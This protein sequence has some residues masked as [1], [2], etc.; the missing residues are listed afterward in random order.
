MARDLGGVPHA[1]VR[2]RQALGL[3]EWP[4]DPRRVG[5]QVHVVEKIAVRED[6]KQP[7]PGHPR[8]QHRE[9][10]IDDDVGT[11]AD[12]TGPR[13]PDGRREEESRQEEDEVRRERDAEEAKKIGMHERE[14]RA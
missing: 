10:E 6:V 1:V 5:A 9:S 3:V 7:R 14:W 13:G 8:E 11:L 12:A 2:S 4:I